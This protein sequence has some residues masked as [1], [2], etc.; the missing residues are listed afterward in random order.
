MLSDPVQWHQKQEAEGSREGRSVVVQDTVGS[1]AGE[2]GSIMLLRSSQNTK[3][4]K[5]FAALDA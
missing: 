2:V 4:E 3:P 1:E 5:A